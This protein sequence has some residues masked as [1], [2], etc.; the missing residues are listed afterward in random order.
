MFVLYVRH[1]IDLLE[2]H[3]RYFDSFFMAESSVDYMKPFKKFA[4]VSDFNIS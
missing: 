3:L 4:K 1:V 2:L